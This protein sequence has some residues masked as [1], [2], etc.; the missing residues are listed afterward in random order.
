KNLGLG[1]A[2]EQFLDKKA[3]ELDIEYE[4]SETYSGK[5]LELIEKLG[6]KKQIVILIDEY[7]KPIIDFLEKDELKTAEQNRRILKN[8]YAGIKDMDKYIKFFFI[9]GVSKFSQVSIFSDLNHLTDITTA[10]DFSEIVGYTEKEIKDNYN[11]YLT[12]LTENLELSKADLLKK[13]KLWYNGYSWDGKKF[14]Y[15]PFSVLSLFFNKDFGN[16]WFETGTPTFLVKKIKENGEP[17][18]NFE[19]INVSKTSFNKYDIDN[20]NTTALLFQTGYLTIKEYDPKRNKYLL[21]YPNKE[22]RD[23]L[24]LF[25]LNSYTNKEPALV[26]TIVD[27]LTAALEETRIDDFMIELKALFESIPYKESE[28]IHNY[29]GYYHSIIYIALK[30]MGIYIEC[31]IMSSRGITDA[32]IKTKKNIFV[33]EFKMGDAE[34]AI[35]QIKDKKY[36]EPYV[37]DKREIILFGIGFDKEERNIKNYITETLNK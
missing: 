19:K 23:S 12:Q 28:H 2:F 32:V 35:K 33:L 7:D 1:E 8:F 24:L 34:T 36:Y 37:A 9:T 5:F 30:I 3:K 17:F 20:L 11:E 18:S 29:E 15:N 10:K 16:Y 31:E 25:S 4:Y 27:R 26:E 6:K 22:V 21:D 13:I 14:L